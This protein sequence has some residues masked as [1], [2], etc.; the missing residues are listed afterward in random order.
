MSKWFT[1]LIVL[2]GGIFK[3]VVKS[4]LIKKAAFLSIFFSIITFIIDYFLGTVQSNLQLE[5]FDLLYYL[6]VVQALQ[7][8][9]SFGITVYIANHLLT[10]FKN[11]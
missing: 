5:F 7:V 6:G 4:P 9:I 1:D 8:F 11:F 3:E 10:Y 2:I